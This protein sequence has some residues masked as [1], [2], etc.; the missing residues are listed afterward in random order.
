[1]RISARQ[2]EEAGDAAAGLLATLPPHVPVALGGDDSFGLLVDAPGARLRSLQRVVDQM[3]E[4]PLA[5]ERR[6]AT[7]S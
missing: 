7:G 4:H 6:L 3:L 2:A 1:M 5:R